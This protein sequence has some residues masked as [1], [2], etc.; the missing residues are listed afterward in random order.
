MRLVKL[1]KN[2]KYNVPTIVAQMFEAPMPNRHFSYKQAAEISDTMTKFRDAVKAERDSVIL[3]NAEHKLLKQT[4]EE[5][6]FPFMNPE[7][8]EVLKAI[9]EAENYELKEVS[10]E[11]H[12]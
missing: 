12:A 2:E 5:F 11:K 1:V 9:V 10:G 6:Q 8:A 7:L 3:E 4:V